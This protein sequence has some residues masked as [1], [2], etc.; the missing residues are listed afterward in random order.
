M[1]LGTTITWRR[2]AIR[3]ANKI[4]VAVADFSGPD[5][6][7][8]VTETLYEKMRQTVSA[9]PE[10]DVS[11]TNGHNV[12]DARTASEVAKREHASVLI[13]DSYGD[14]GGDVA[15]FLHF[16]T[17]RWKRLTGEFLLESHMHVQ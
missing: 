3:E 10:I 7:Y 17:Y 12:R 13:W 1:V 2:N 15:L 8:K 14:T 5:V 6:A 16:D 11:W 4:R 9:F